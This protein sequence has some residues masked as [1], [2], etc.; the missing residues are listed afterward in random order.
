[1]KIISVIMLLLIS[2]FALSEPING[3]VAYCV[4]DQGDEVTVIGGF[5]PHSK[6][7]HCHVG[8]GS[9]YLNGEFLTETNFDSCGKEGLM[10]ESAL[11]SG[12]H[13][14]YILIS[15]T[16]GLS[17]ISETQRSENELIVLNQSKLQCEFAMGLW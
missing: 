4:S 13:F 2:N 14:H 15:G 6:A 10:I 9:V 17:E 5:Q 1:M 16:E 12:S 11:Q 7:R 8:S 3:L